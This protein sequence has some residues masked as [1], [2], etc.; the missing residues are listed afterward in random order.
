M[1]TK[2]YGIWVEPYETEDTPHWWYTEWIVWFTEN[3]SL[4]L[5][6]KVIVKTNYSPQATLTVCQLDDDG[7]PVAT[8][9]RN[10]DLHL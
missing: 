8:I 9:R 5:A 3:L 1:T 4:A 2:L 10:D 7:K 6:Q